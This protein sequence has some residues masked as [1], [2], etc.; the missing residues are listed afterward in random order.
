MIT[1]PIIAAMLI[2]SVSTVNRVASASEANT[3]AVTEVHS[4][5]GA[6]VSMSE[7]L[8]AEAAII[9]A[10]V[11]A[12]KG[13]VLDDSILEGETARADQFRA[14]ASNLTVA[15]GVAANVADTDTI[16]NPAWF[17]EYD[18]AFEKLDG[19]E[20]RIVNTVAFKLMDGITENATVVSNAVTA[21]KAEQA[22]LAEVARLAKIAAEAAVAKAAAVRAHVSSYTS[23]PGNYNVYV[24]TS[25]NGANAQS[26]I[27]AGGQVAVSYGS[28]TGIIVSAHN[29]HD[30]TALRLQAGDIVTFSGAVSGSFRVTGSISVNKY[31]TAATDVLVLGTYMHM[32]T[33]YFGGSQ[34]RV[35]GMVQI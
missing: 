13:K 2:T 12:A 22:R 34:M 19:V 15:G 11:A 23:S 3:A 29:N 30:S 9:D 33:C 32:Q 16:S 24:R 28:G 5:I 14:A 31:G 10:S 17:W 26:A 4:K 35:V 20:F 7:S 18:S 27:N 6:A 21:W 25:A 1:F 8:L